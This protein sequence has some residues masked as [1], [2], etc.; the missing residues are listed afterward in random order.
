MFTKTTLL[1]AGALVLGLGIVAQAGSKDEHNPAGGY[2]V[3]PLSQSFAG[4]NPASHPSM[5]GRVHARVKNG[6]I[7]PR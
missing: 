2:R 1:V 7:S 6:S 4:A 5:R 3:G